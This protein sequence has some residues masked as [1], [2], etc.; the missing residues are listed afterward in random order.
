MLS[1]PRGAFRHALLLLALP[2]DPR[3]AGP[4]RLVLA[5]LINPAWMIALC[6]E[7]NAQVIPLPTA[8]AALVGRWAQGPCDLPLR[9]DS[10]QFQNL[11]GSPDPVAWPEEVQARQF[12]ANGGASLFVVRLRSTGAYS[13]RC[14]QVY[15]PGSHF[16]KLQAR[17]EQ[18]RN[19]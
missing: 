14:G 2:P 5:S 10:A 18:L 16:A 11:F 17:V 9:V 15:W 8:Q 12:F 1:C 3:Y 13:R 19:A 4:M 6:A 7:A